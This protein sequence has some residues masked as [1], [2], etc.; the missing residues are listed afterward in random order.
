MKRGRKNRNTKPGTGKV[1][2]VSPRKAGRGRFI[3][4]KLVF[5]ILFSIIIIRLFKIQVLDGSEYRE[6]AKKQY[7][8][9]KELTASRGVVY[10]RKGNILISNT[11]FISFAADPFIL[12]NNI[13]KVAH[14]FSTV[15]GKSV[16]HYLQRI[17]GGRKF[18]WLERRVSPDYLQ[19]I[20]LDVDGL[21]V[22]P[23][24][25]RLYHY[26]DLAREVLGVTNVD[27]V[28]IS[29]V[30][31]Q[32]DDTLR[33][34]NGYMVMQRDGKMRSFPTV[35]YP[36]EEA[37]NGN[38]LV[39]TIDLSLQSIAEEELKRGIEHND[40][41]SGLVVLM[42]PK[43]GAILSMAN[44]P[45]GGR[46]RIIT[47]MFEPG[48]VFKIVTAASVI[49]HNLR[50][51]SDMIYAEGGKYTGAGGRVIRDSEEYEWLTVREAMMY[52]SNIA[53]A[54]LSDEIGAERLYKMSRDFGF[55]IP[56][57][58]ELPGEVRGDLKR[59]VQWS[60]T[61]LHTMAFG[62]EV[63]VTPLQL[64][65][66]YAAIANRGILMRPYLVARELDTRGKTLYEAKPQQIRR[67]VN[68]ATAD[69]LAAFFEDVVRGG[70][71][72]NARIQGVRIAGK[73]GTARKYVDGK[74]SSSDYTVSFVGFFPVEDPEIVCLV[75]M[76]NPRR[77]G[78][79][80]STTSVPVFRNIAERIITTGLLRVPPSPPEEFEQ[81]QRHIHKTSASQ[82]IKDYSKPRVPDVRHYPV[83][84]AR[85]ILDRNGYRVKVEGDGDG[86]VVDQQP[87]PGTRE[88]RSTSVKLAALNRNGDNNEETVAT[89]D[90][91]GLTVRSA[92]NRLLVEGL[93]LEI[94][95]SGIVVQQSVTPGE[96]VRPGTIVRVQCRPKT[97]ATQIAG[98]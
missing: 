21:I 90:L 34:I 71:G 23:E 83:T 37:V 82:K 80:A 59:P 52:S 36:R 72:T 56:T 78:Y 91:R 22:S 14:N 51:G 1:K 81:M 42:N 54:K 88:E 89:P 65:A 73:T 45:P 25:K 76:D 70:T 62:Y 55:G 85:Q 31:L 30:E 44:Y 43:T 74:Y 96:R 98:H 28:G 27:N 17:R 4:V 49:E 6:I 15:F 24:P 47:D 11:E 41:E 67:V 66:A 10:D 86:I 5:F 18:V 95:G 87:Q 46:N 35:D 29:G 19:Q 8:I 7:E 33:G 84:V 13:D 61:T 75:M 63:A 93:S 97:G 79:Y 9:Q 57:G 12:G 16:A 32:Y 39:L 26:G 69:T 40:A 77:G 50:T 48:S 38:N 94:S 53:M 64:A 68:T 60:G 3:L 2:Y 58:I 92:L 20:N